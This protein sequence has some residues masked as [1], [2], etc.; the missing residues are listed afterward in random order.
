MTIEIIIVLLILIAVVAFL[1]TELM[2]LEVLA[3]LVLGVL[4]VSGIVTP[5]EALAGF[6]SPAVVTIW[7]V[8]I[9]SGGLTQTGIANILGRQLLKVAGR[10]SSLLTVIIMAIAGILSAF[11]N[12]VAVA[13]LML[14]VVMDITRKTEH[15]PSAL[16]MPLAYGSLLGGLTTMIG[17]PPNILVSEALRENGLK[18]F[19]LFDFTPVGLTIMISGIVFVIFVGKRLLPR[20]GKESKKTGITKDFR[21][22]YELQKRLFQVRIPSGSALIGKT[23]GKSRLGSAFGLNVVSIRRGK[24]NLLAPEITEIIHANDILIVEG[25]IDHIQEMNHWGQLE[26]EKDDITADDLYTHGMKVAELKLNQGSTFAGKTFSE[27]GFRKLLVLMS[28]L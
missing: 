26:L 5:L 8:F 1:V 2:P 11:M 13:A 3:F 9:L 20:N 16:L 27:T 7:A 23:L 24:N 21:A 18:P 12:N 15:S 14:P 17:T 25:R 28:W 22:Q 6:S 10:S 19:S 4:A